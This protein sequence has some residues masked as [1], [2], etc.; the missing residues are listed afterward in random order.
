MREDIFKRILK[1]QE[2][3][4]AGLDSEQ[5]RF[6]DKLVTKGRRYGE[7]TL[8]VLVFNI[9]VFQIKFSWK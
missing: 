3:G 1:V 2:T 6:V 4:T 9:E 5:K 8:V 7:A